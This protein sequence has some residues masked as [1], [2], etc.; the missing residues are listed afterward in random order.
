MISNF[1]FTFLILSL[2]FLFSCTKE[3][4]TLPPAPDTYEF[5]ALGHP[6]TNDNST[7]D[8]EVSQMNFDP[9]DLLLLGGDIAWSTSRDT[10]ILHLMDSIFDIKSETTLWALG[11]HD[12]TNPALIEDFTGKP[13]FYHYAFKN[14][15]FVILDTEDSLTSFTQPQHDLLKAVIDTLQETTHLIL[16]HHKLGWMYGH[17][18][19]E[20][21]IDAI[22]NGGSGDCNYCTNPNNFYERTYPLLLQ[23]KNK[24]VEVIC[25]AGDIGNKV[26]SFDYLTDEGIHFIGTGIE[27][28]QSG[29]EVLLFEYTPDIDLLSWRHELLANLI[30]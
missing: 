11:N 15:S 28:N 10:G 3:E 17:P 25:L 18:E 27:Y 26:T 5:L 20:S 12:Y 30:E 7:I 1:K 13:N 14:I 22:T 16:L 9:Y 4:P 6:R 29:N 21:Q 19:L 23:V 8:P 24:G 2:L